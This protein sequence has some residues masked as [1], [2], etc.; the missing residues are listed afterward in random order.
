MLEKYW[1][2]QNTGQHTD[3]PQCNAVGKF[4]VQNAIPKIKES[5]I[6][7]LKN[8]FSIKGGSGI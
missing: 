6:R 1:T 8:K 3:M 4:R 7:N 2:T 5:K